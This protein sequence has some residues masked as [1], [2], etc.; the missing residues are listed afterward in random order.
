[1]LDVQR[2]T[3]IKS[4]F[5]K[6]EVKSS[7]LHRV[8]IILEY[9]KAVES[10]QLQPN[11]D[12]LREAKALASRLPLVLRDNVNGQDDENDFDS[13]FYAHMAD[14]TLLAYLGAVLKSCNNLNQFVN[15]FNGL[16]QRQGSARRMRGIFF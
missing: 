8:R 9:V 12:I 14:G 5:I 16:Y 10:G 11:H 6:I 4:S 2:C 15:K 7:F 1:M 13:E 3:T